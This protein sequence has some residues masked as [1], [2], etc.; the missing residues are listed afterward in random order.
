MRI[1]RID[2]PDDTVLHIARHG[3]EPDE[4]EEVCF[5]GKPFIFKARYNRYYALGQ[6]K[7][8][9]YLAVIFEYLGQNKAQI[10]TARAMS[11]AERK[12]YQRQRR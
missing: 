2:W 5:E 7:N 6:T 10:V 11:G 9:R 12:L 3:V 1:N 4:I 8:G